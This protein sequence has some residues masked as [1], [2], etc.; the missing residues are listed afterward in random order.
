[1]KNYTVLNIQEFESGIQSKEFY[2]NTMENHL[3]SGH[4]NIHK[5]H[6]HNFYVTVFFTHGS[7]VHEIDFVSYEVIP[8]SLFFLNPG[9]MHY[10]DLS[11]DISGF[12]FFH[13]QPFYDLHF[14]KSRIANFPFFYSVQNE[15]VLYLEETD[16]SYFVSLFEQI[17]KETRSEYLFKMQ[18]IKVLIDLVYIESTRLYIGKDDFD[19]SKQHSYYKKFQE[20][21]Q[22]VEQHYKEEKSASWFADKLNISPKHLNRIVREMVGKTTTDIILERVFLEAKREFIARKF[23]FNEISDDLGYDDYAYFSRLF[24]KKCGETPSE[25]VNRYR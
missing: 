11:E 8:G 25:F 12:I 4:K 19:V 9:Q 21:E 18:K 1:M 2:S 10:W 22:L 23:N 5:P 3:V 16:S 6:R 20:L 24:K 13:T 14:A 15:P 7:G 17:Y